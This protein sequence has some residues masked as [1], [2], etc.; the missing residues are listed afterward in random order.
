MRCDMD[1]LP[2]DFIELADHLWPSLPTDAALY[3]LCLTTYTDR[4]TGEERQAPRVHARF[5]GHQWHQRRPL[6]GATYFSAAAW[7]D[8]CWKKATR[9]QVRAV[10]SLWADIDPVD[11]ES[12]VDVVAV[13]ESLRASGLR[14][15][16]VDSGRGVQVWQALD[17]V[18]RVDDYER[19][20]RSLRRFGRAV[21]ETCGVAGA[22]LDL[23]VAEVSRI[24]RVPGTVNRRTGRI[25]ALHCRGE[26]WSTKRMGDWLDRWA[27]LEAPPKEW[28][29]P[30]PEKLYRKHVAALEELGA[31]PAGMRGY[32]ETC[33]LAGLKLAAAEPGTIAEAEAV[34]RSRSAPECAEHN[35]KSFRRAMMTASLT[36]IHHATRRPRHTGR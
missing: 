15:T 32:N 16:V 24:M 14:P 12:V 11:G 4:E 36:G 21:N 23:S 31:H 9:E 10:S 19:V 6:E 25:A 2:P 3:V 1:H 8:D 28:K 17:E 5:D 33:F 29:P 30:T 27:P 22:K 20:K 26:R 35:V 7:A 13:T 34:I 18:I